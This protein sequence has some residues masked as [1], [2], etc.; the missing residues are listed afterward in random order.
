MSSCSICN[1]EKQIGEERKMFT[2]KIL[3][4]ERGAEKMVYGGGRETTITTTYGEFLEQRYFVC[5]NCISF[6]NKIIVPIAAVITII[7]SVIILYLALTLHIDWLFAL[8]LVVFIAGIIIS[9]EFSIHSKLQK[10]AKKDR[11]E[12]TPIKAFS[13]NE[14]KD[15]VEKNNRT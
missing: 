3:K 12:K 10:K 7:L 15:L 1:K 13:E 8:G 9:G 4:E 2:A 6:W 5:G 11:N 14:Y